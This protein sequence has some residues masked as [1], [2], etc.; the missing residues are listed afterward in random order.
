[1]DK[2]MEILER[3][4]CL[5]YTFAWLGLL[6]WLESS[7]AFER[8]FKRPMA[9]WHGVVLLLIFVALAVV[10][11]DIVNGFIG[12]ALLFLYIGYKIGFKHK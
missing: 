11:P 2:F 4:Y 7:G 12:V 9:Y 1:M 6:D 3:F 5:I 10:L 8:V